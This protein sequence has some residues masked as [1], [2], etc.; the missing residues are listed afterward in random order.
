MIISH[1]TRFI[2]PIVPIP[3]PAPGTTLEI[4]QGLTSDDY[5]LETLVGTSP[6]NGSS[7]GHGVLHEEPGRPINVKSSG[8]EHVVAADTGFY[9]RLKGQ[10]SHKSKLAI[11]YTSFSYLGSE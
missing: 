4:R 5:L 9:V 10:F 6:L 1:S 2:L 8:K 11:V 3:L 7:A